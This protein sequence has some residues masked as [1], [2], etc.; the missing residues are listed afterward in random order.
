M[1]K[2]NDFTYQYVYKYGGGYYQ[3]AV[4]YNGKEFTGNSTTIRQAYRHAKRAIRRWKRMEKKL[5]N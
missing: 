5:G 2:G 4:R 1:S 3:W